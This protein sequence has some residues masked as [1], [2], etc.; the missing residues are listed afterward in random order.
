MELDLIFRLNKLFSEKGWH[1]KDS[2]IA[3]F[4]SLCTLMKHLNSRDEQ[5]LLIEL[6]ERYTWITYSE[7]QSIL[8]NLSKKII[9]S[10][11]FS[12]INKVILFPMMNPEDEARTKSGHVLAYNLEPILKDKLLRMQTSFIYRIESYDEILK[13]DFKINADTLFFIV[14]DYIGSGSTLENTIK[15]ILQNKN[16]NKQQINVFSISAQE[17]S[18]KYLK[19]NGITFYIDTILKKGITDYYSEEEFEEKSQTMLNI[20]KRIYKLKEYSFGYKQ[21]EAL[22]TLAKTPNNTFPIFWKHYKTNSGIKLEPTF[23]R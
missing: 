3:I 1:S 13:D 15:Y 9:D 14:D 8:V 19:E 18:L 2:N 21:T 4:E 12:N 20:E 22:V 6:I 23:I 17:L 16:I 7:Y 5:E 11:I 10:G